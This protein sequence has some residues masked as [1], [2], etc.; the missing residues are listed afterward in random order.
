MKERQV[1]LFVQQRLLQWNYST[2]CVRMLCCYY[3][4]VLYRLHARDYVVTIEALY[5]GYVM[6]EITCIIMYALYIFFIL[7]YRESPGRLYIYVCIDFYREC[8]PFVLTPGQHL[9]ISRIFIQ[10]LYILLDM[11]VSCFTSQQ[12]GQALYKSSHS[13]M[14]EQSGM[15]CRTGISFKKTLVIMLFK[16]S[17]SKFF[18]TCTLT[19]IASDSD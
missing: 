14:P 9:V 4:N 6:L 2:L 13:A 10:R 11:C 19:G 16:H 1:Y 12:P 18:V 5:R 15:K 8:Q 3:R 7:F 17:C